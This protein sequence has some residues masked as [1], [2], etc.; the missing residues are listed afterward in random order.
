MEL[1]VVILIISILS[2]VV[3][4][5]LF[6]RTDEARVAAVKAQLENFRTA[7]NLYKMDNGRLPTQHQGLEALVQQ[8]T[9]DPK[10]HKFPPEGYLDSR[11]LPMDPWG[12]D[13]IYLIPGTQGE[14][15]EIISYGRDGEPGGE[16]P[17]ADIS[18]SDL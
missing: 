16:G 14:T 1:L 9:I 11:T 12:H 18:T 4:V 2:T 15:Y 17:D 6:G 13:Y 10:P 3:G 8:S 5:K 7:L